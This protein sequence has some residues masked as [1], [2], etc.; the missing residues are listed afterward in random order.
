MEKSHT[1]TPR[2]RLEDVDALP[3][4]ALVERAKPML[5]GILHSE[6]PDYVRAHHE[7]NVPYALAL[8]PMD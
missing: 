8:L 2:L 3:A 5:R 6:V 4:D 7:E 1:H